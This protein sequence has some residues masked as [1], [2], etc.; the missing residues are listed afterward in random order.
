MTTFIG[1][2]SRLRTYYLDDHEVRGI[3]FYRDGAVVVR[4]RNG[5]IEQEG[6]SRRD[7]P[8]LSLTHPLRRSNKINLDKGGHFFVT[9][10]KGFNTKPGVNLYIDLAL[11]DAV[12]GDEREEVLYELDSGITYHTIRTLRAVFEDGGER[13]TIRIGVGQPYTRLN[14]Y[15]QVLEQIA[16]HLRASNQEHAVRGIEVIVKDRH[17]LDLLLRA[18]AL[19]DPGSALPQDMAVAATRA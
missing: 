17:L 19:I 10:E 4:T 7:L 16:G 2:Q 6:A 13:R 14:G 1:K 3:Y 9:G 5:W 18:H 11:D 8:G 12:I 15:G